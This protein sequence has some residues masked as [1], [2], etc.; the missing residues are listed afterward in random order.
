MIRI[1]YSSFKRVIYLKDNF[2][3]KIA[4]EISKIVAN[5]REYDKILL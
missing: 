3:Y 5:K 2:D 4:S 1:E